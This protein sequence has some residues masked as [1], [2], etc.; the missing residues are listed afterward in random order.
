MSTR[1][2]SFA[3][4]RN[5]RDI[6]IIVDRRQT[7]RYERSGKDGDIQQTFLIKPFF[8]GFLKIAQISR[9][10][11]EKMSDGKTAFDTIEGN[12]DG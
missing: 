4:P 7:E 9:W 2:E 3:V 11:L 1:I 10:L 12:K 8:S 6:L 5:I